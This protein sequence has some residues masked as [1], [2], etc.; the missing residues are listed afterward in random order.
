MKIIFRYA[1]TK[2][3]FRIK[4]LGGNRGVIS[5]AML[6]SSSSIEVDQVAALYA[7][8]TIRSQFDPRNG[9]M[10]F[11]ESRPSFTSLSVRCIG[12]CIFF[13]K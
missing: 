7:C 2:E 3:T 11:W 12:P 1:K 10:P 8:V 5:F 9:L 13:K 4:F 6:A